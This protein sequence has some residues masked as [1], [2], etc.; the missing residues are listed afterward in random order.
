MRLRIA[1][2]SFALLICVAG[3]PVYGSGDL[4]D[5]AVESDEAR[6]PGVE[7]AKTLATATGI[8]ITPLL[9]VSAVGAWQY[10]ST[11]STLRAA[12]PWYSS[13][14]FWIPG[15]V[16]AFLLVVKDPLLGIIPG[17][18]KPLDAVDVLENKASALL[19][20]P[21]VVPMFLSA[22]STAG[23][24]RVA[25]GGEG[26]IVTQAGI[27]AM[28]GFLRDLPQAIGLGIGALVFLAAFLCIWLAFHTINVLILLSPF[29]PLDLFLRSLKLL[30]LVVLIGGT[31]IHPYLGLAVS[32]AILLVAIPLAG[33]S[34][35]LMV[36]GGVLATDLLTLRHRREV[37]D[38]ARLRV[39][40]ARELEGVGART[41]GDVSRVETG[42]VFRYRPWLLLP[43]RTVLLS[44][45][46]YEIGRGLVCPILRWQQDDGDAVSLLRFPPRYRSHEESLMATLDV[47]GV[48]DLR[49][50]RGLKACVAWVKEMAGR[51][52][53]VAA[54][55]ASSAR[56][57]LP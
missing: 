22:F 12:L 49:L 45:G 32:I 56:D 19:A 8:A 29:G 21:A 33:W 25:T 44:P 1:I 34:F 28:P 10:Y 6:L 3:M 50:R 24:M 16:I 7:L 18:K 39:F 57:A 40:T 5:A 48:Q 17:A 37:P 53:E 46:A 15:L 9:G 41:Y 36:F 47:A 42:I 13:R 51:G 54:Q 4:I 27:A 2:A 11:D 20:T 43:R 31:L 35:R 52:G 14:W 55:M 38:P 23:A 30:S 26:M